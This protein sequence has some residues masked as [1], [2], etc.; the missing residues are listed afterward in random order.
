MKKPTPKNLDRYVRLKK[1]EDQGIVAVTKHLFDIEDQLQTVSEEIVAAKGE[2]GDKGDQ[3]EQ[4]LPG[5]DGQDGPRG[6]DGENGKDGKNGRD[7]RDGID[8]VNGND[9]R[10]GRDGIDGK[11]GSPDSPQ[12]VA[13]KVNTL[14]EKIK[15]D[16]IIGW[17]DLQNKIQS[18][19]PDNFDV[20]IGVSKTEIK[21]L[22]NR[23]I[24]LESSSGSGGG[25]TIQDEGSGLTQRTNLN[26]VGAGVTVTDDSGNDATKVTIS[27]SAGTALNKETPVGSVDDSNVTFTVSNEPFYLN[28]NGQILEVGDGVYSSYSLGTITLSV[29]VGAGGFIKSYYQA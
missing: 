10:D 28:V 14:Y 25:H 13:D 5:K 7:G 17:K 6:M 24:S 27:G 12:Q 2:K 11:D 21:N 20:R 3:G 22:T 26:F 23:I 4:G 16:V 18:K 19:V 1:L 29:P 8:G 9:G 15:P